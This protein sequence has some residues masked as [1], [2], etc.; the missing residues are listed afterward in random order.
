VTENPLVALY[1]ACQN[2]QEKKIT[3][4]K[5]ALL[6]PT[7]GKSITSATTEKVIAT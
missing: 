6:P 7:D 4:G 1:F 5:T 3:D 2:N